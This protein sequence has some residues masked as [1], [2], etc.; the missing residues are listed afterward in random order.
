[1]ASYP[2]FAVRVTPRSEVRVG[3]Q[4]SLRGLEAYVPTQQV[5]RRWS[6][7]SRVL[8]EPLFPGYLFCR[9]N[10]LEWIRI[11]EVPGAIQVLSIGNSPIP[12]PEAEIESIRAVLASGSIVTPWPYLQAGQQVRIDAGPLAGVRGIVLRSE[13]GN[14]RVVVSVTLLQRSVAA[15]IERDWIGLA[16]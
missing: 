8:P 9:F 6:D 16:G 11:V 5:K 3:G 4:L 15:E 7:R 12:I 14:P 2:W 1:M 13:S 10:P